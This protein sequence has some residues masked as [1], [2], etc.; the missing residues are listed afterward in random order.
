M[1]ICVWKARRLLEVFEEDRMR[2]R[3]SV[4]LGFGAEDGPK[5]REGDGRTPEGTYYVCMKNAHSKFFLS[6][7]I[8]YPGPED[9]RRALEEG[10]ISEETALDIAQAW[11]HKARPPWNTSLGG[12]IMIHGQPS[13]GD[14]VGDWTAG[15]IALENRDMQLLFSM[16]ALGD[17][18]E[19]LP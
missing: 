13:Q 17:P 7:G 12:W 10:R 9:A 5:R 3:A 2:L 11:K 14:G 16:A 15:C 6:L 8:S 4:Q 1:K 19:L 18:V